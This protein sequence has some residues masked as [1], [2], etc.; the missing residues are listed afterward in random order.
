M[1]QSIDVGYRMGGK[2]EHYDYHSHQEYEIYFFHSGVC[3]YLID[4]H[5]Y[6]LQPGDIILMD[7]LTLHRPYTNPKI[8]YVRSIM[9][10]SPIV[11]QDILQTL[12][13][14]YLLESFQQRPHYLIRTK[15]NQLSKE[16]EDI[17]QKLVTTKRFIHE[18]RTKRKDEQVL[19]T[20]LT[21]LLIQALITVHKL[22]EK[23]DLLIT[24]DTNIKGEHSENIATYI[25]NHY[26][27]N[28][29]VRSIAKALNLSPSYASHLF[30]KQTGF[31]IMEYVM[32]RRL[33]QAKFLL[34]MKPD[35]KVKEIAKACGFNS[36]AHFSR[37]FR[38]EIGMT[39]LEYRRKRLVFK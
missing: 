34:E 27:E 7:G 29:S 15:E 30:K 28:L 11:I 12:N 22:Y 36:D 16:L 26:M 39:A 5:I 33:N 25:Q 17:F 3:R 8:E 37:F 6:D 32:E 10:F 9:H 14:R 38:K 23:K 35:K 4:N 19:Q 18:Y 20:E 21:M 1:D 2:L 24:K 31:S 13:A